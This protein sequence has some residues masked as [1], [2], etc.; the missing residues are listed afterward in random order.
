MEHTDELWCY[1]SD[2][3][4]VMAYDTPKEKKYPDNV[5]WSE[6]RGYYAHL[7]PYV[8]NVGAPVIIPDNV[9]TW[10]N[11]KILKTNHYFNKKYEEIKEQY[12][13]LVEEFEWNQMVYSANYNFQPIIGEK[14]YLYRRNNG[15]TFLSLIT[16]T[17][18]KQEF[19]GAFE[20]DS[21]NKWKKIKYGK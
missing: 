7:L 19:I 9:A 3:P 20:L 8:T 10:K 14:Y 11:E 21:D 15:E 13:K 12:T 2:L 1:Y 18:W 6:E 5:V 16:P 4:S 17:E